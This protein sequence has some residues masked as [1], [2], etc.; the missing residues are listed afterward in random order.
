MDLLKDL[1]RDLVGVIF[2]GTIFILVFIWLPIGICLPFNIS[3]EPDFW[4]LME[5]IAENT[6]IW[7]F[8]ILFSY[9]AG[10]YL[11]IKMLSELENKAN[12]W[13]FGLTETHHRLASDPKP[14]TW[15]QK[16]IFLIFGTY[17]LRLLRINKE[18]SKSVEEALK[19]DEIKAETEN[20]FTK[21]SSFQT[22]EARTA[23][24]NS[25]IKW[26]R[27]EK[28]PFYYVTKL[29][30]LRG[31][32]KL[33]NDFF[34]AFDREGVLQRTTF[35]NYCKSVI[36]EYSPSLKEELLRTEA[37]VRLMAGLY[38]SFHS[39]ILVN[40]IILFWQVLLFILHYFRMAIGDFQFHTVN[41]QTSALISLSAFFIF[42]IAILI[43]RQTLNRIQNRRMKEVHLTYEG[44]YLLSHKYEN[45]RQ[46]IPKSNS[47]E[48]K[49]KSKKKS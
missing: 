30:R 8:F 20:L 9:I 36:Y 1:I 42:I 34:D 2:P 15:H 13:R 33:Y 7:L 26:Y 46:L 48:K 49:K 16:L 47:T 23:L 29:R 41:L 28:A 44:F 24:Y 6:F 17:R 4:V 14:P 3:Q 12:I 27:R 40:L 43:K 19:N 39:A 21:Y 18:Y 31:Q 32:S 45:L 38:Y 35:F 11:R 5:Q 22:Q 25:A 37:L 10:Q